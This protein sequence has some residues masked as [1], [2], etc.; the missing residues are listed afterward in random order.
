MLQK[1]TMESVIALAMSVATVGMT[2][3]ALLLPAPEQSMTVAPV[4]RAVTPV[5]S[6]APAAAAMGAQRS[7]TRRPAA[8][9][10]CGK[11]ARPAAAEDRGMT[12]RQAAADDRGTRARQ[13]ATAGRS[14]VASEAAAPAGAPGPRMCALSPLHHQ[15]GKAASHRRAAPFRVS[16]SAAPESGGAAGRA[17]VEPVEPG[18]ASSPGSTVEHCGDKLPAE[19]AWLAHCCGAAE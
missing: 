1:P 6:A 15:G 3:A 4:A 7:A 10:D 13:A 9:D 11:T 16:G 14:A 8:A 2:V 12:A 17:P 19:V 5:A 18:A